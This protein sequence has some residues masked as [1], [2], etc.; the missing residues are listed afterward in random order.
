M[1]APLIDRQQIATR[2]GLSYRYVRD[3][4]EAI[5]E[6]IEEAG[7]AHASFFVKQWLQTDAAAPVVRE[8][9]A[10]GQVSVGMCSAWEFCEL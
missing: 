5:A 8:L 6:Q 9:Q 4:A 10:L 2:H 3:V 1:S 7:G